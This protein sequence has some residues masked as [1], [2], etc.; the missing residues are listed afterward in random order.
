MVE[1]GGNQA[2][3]V[4][5]HDFKSLTN[6]YIQHTSASVSPTPHRE[7]RRER[8]HRD[9]EHGGRRSRQV[10]DGTT[11]NQLVLSPTP[12]H[13]KSSRRPPT[14]ERGNVPRDVSTQPLA[15]TSRRA[16]QQPQRD[17]PTNPVLPPSHPY[18]TP[19]HRTAAAPIPNGGSDSFWQQP[20]KNRSGSREEI[21]VQREIV[22]A[23]DQMQG[24]GEQDKDVGHRKGIWATLC[25]RM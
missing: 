20:G 25:C 3:C 8:E 15:P 1:K 17:V 6:L 12:A 22:R 16:S 2:M 11:P 18:A 21:T 19:R 24:V 4:F 10:P 23:F 5:R 13:V 9:R 14:G 7:H